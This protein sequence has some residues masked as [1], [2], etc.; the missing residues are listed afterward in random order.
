MIEQLRID[1]FRGLDALGT[2]SL[3]R[4][5]V[6]VGPCGSGK[7]AL[8]EAVLLF[9]ETGY[10]LGLLT[11]LQQ[12]GIDAAAS[13]TAAEWADLL[14][15]FASVGRDPP[16]CQLSGTWNGVPR[17]VSIARSTSAIVRPSTEATVP[18]VK[19]VGLLLQQAAASFE[20][21]TTHGLATATGSLYATSQ[22]L[23]QVQSAPGQATPFQTRFMGATAQ[24]TAT[25]SLAPLWTLT[26]DRH[27][28]SAVEDLLRTFDS[29]VEAVRV[30]A[31]SS[32]TAFVRVLHKQ[33]GPVPLELLGDGFSKALTLG[34]NLAPSAGG[35][36]LIDEFEASLDVG[37]LRRVV[38][39]VTAAARRL[40]VQLFLSTHSLDTVD[41]FLDAAEPDE[42]R[43]L[44]L[45][46]PLAPRRIHN[47]D[48]ERA[49]LL[50][51]D[52]GL[53][54]RRAG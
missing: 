17:T 30:A 51:E 48:Q 33:L 9:G 16:A 11:A 34:C 21:S 18:G 45:D 24:R 25:Q 15:W 1:G 37:A 32:S 39:F 44:R 52:V 23:V 40:D 41:A 42:L 38:E 7:T 2:G 50:R 8:L 4:I 31:G 5:N 6:V 35:V 13:R 3:G 43:V 22:G 20:M 19:D 46:H 12:R 54:L 10:P 29:D 26:E 14:S 47:L 28:A 53:D 49:R 36:L 27:E